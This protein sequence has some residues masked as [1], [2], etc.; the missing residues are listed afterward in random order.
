MVCTLAVSATFVVDAVVAVV[1]AVGAVAAVVEVSI[2]RRVRVVSC[3]MKG[4]YNGVT[5]KVT[6]TAV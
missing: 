6:G 2:S 3:D 5:A 1:A 4:V